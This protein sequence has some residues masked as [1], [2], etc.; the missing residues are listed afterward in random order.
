MQYKSYERADVGWSWSSSMFIQVLCLYK[1]CGAMHL[2][3]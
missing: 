2:H 3:L 1:Y